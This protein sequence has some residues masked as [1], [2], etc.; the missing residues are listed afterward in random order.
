MLNRLAF[1]RHGYK[2]KRTTD[3]ACVRLGA[4]AC[5]RTHRHTCAH[6][7][8]H[9][10]IP[11]ARHVY[12]RGGRATNSH[13]YRHTP[14][15]KSQKVQPKVLKWIP[16]MRNSCRF[17]LT[18]HHVKWVYYPNPPHMQSKYITLLYDYRDTQHDTDRS[19]CRI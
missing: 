1:R 8:M 19:E 17:L 5:M 18:G 12:R 13:A 11:S 7:H 3:L 4:R 14:Q 15:T 16:P 9:T 10:H 6:I 2:V